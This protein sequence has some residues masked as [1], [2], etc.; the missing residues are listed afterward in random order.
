[1]EIHKDCPLRVN[2]LILSKISIQAI[3]LNISYL[4]GLKYQRLNF[5]YVKSPRSSIEG[6][7][8][9]F[10]KITILSPICINSASTL[11]DP[12]WT[13]K[14]LMFI[15]RFSG[16]H[17]GLKIIWFLFVEIILM[18]L[19]KGYYWN[20]SENRTINLQCLIYANFMVKTEF[21]IPL[22]PQNIQYQAEWCQVT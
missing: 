18:L 11:P 20:I 5:E 22:K 2:T 19:N 16:A 7:Q 9:N 14:F 21:V 17:T 6:I 1:M 15:T 8:V 3:Q 10:A 4:G 12:T 13:M